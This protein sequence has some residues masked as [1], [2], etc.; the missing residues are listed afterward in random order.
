VHLARFHGS[1]ARVDLRTLRAP[2]EEQ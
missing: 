1:G 2:F